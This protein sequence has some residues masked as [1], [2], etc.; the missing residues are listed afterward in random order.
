MGVLQNRGVRLVAP[1]SGDFSTTFSATENPISESG[2]WQRGASEGVNWLDPKTA[3]GHA[4]AD[5]ASDAGNSNATGA[6][7]STGRYDDSLAH[8]K[9]S[10]RTFNADQFVQVV[11][12]KAAAYSPA[13][14]HEAEMLLRFAITANNA[15]G[16]EVLVGHAGNMALVRWNGARGD[17][18]ALFEAGS[19]GALVDGDVMRAEITGQ[20]AACR[21]RVYKNGAELTGNGS[22]FDVNVAGGTVWNSGQPGLGFWPVDTGN[23]PASYGWDS[24]TAGNL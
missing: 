15:R 24:Y 4:T 1:V 3:S 12:Y 10:F 14:Q 6:P 17:Y 11:A 16:Y 2:I 13:G 9:T 18:T 5:L 23:V 19:I 8:L 22:P 20:N 7:A 21:I